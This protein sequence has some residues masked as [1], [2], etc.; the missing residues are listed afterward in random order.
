MNL[1]HLHGGKQ[2]GRKRKKVRSE[3][4]LEVALAR[5]CR[6]RR[7]RAPQVMLHIVAISQRGRKKRLYKGTGKLRL[8]L[9]CWCMV[10]FASL[11]GSR[12]SY[13]NARTTGPD[14]VLRPHGR[15]AKRTAHGLSLG[16]MVKNLRRAS[17]EG[18]RLRRQSLRV[19]EG[20]WV[21]K[22]NTSRPC[23]TTP[24]R[25]EP[26]SVDASRFPSRCL[27]PRVI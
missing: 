24:R 1:R 22:G 26:S 16:T 12:H 9:S 23:A 14:F 18:V 3:F 6:E 2:N 20:L 7:S 15:W 25:V 5:N 8:Y 11:V 10:R 17:P 4:P 19:I 27:S 13:Q 21:S